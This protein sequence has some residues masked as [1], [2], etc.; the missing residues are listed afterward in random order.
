MQ[1]TLS[2]GPVTLKDVY[3]HKMDRVFNAELFRGGDATAETLYNAYDVIILMLAEGKTQ[4][5]LDGLP[6]SDYE[7]LKAAVDQLQGD[8][9]EEGKKNQ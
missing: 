1:I 2:S 5:W 7:K 6:K 4:E 3:T 8:G 9:K